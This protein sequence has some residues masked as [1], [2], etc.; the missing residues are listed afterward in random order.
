MKKREITQGS[1]ITNIRSLKYPNFPCLGI[2][3]S[4]RC[5]FAQDKIQNFYLLS[6]L[7]IKLWINDVFV[8][9]ILANDAAK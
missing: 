8:D 6:A 1:I 5:D 2:V 9:E 4:A 7:P 3:I